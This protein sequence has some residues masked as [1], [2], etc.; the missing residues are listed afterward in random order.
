[1]A[2]SRHIREGVQAGEAQLADSNAE[3]MLKSF[4]SSKIPIK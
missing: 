1:M 4:H 2:V 3:G